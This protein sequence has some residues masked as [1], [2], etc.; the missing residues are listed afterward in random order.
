M[1]GTKRKAT[2][3]PAPSTSKHPKVKKEHD[4]SLDDE[5]FGDFIDDEQGASD[6]E[7]DGDDV[8]LTKELW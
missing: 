3:P 1:K 8:S 2:A 7:N 5:D 4:D 6:N